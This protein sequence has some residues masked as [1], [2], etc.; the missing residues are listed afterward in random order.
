M[1]LGCACAALG[2]VLASCGGGGKGSEPGPLTRLAPTAAMPLSPGNLD[3]QDEDPSILVGR[4]GDSLWAAWYSN[5]AGLH[6]S[7]RERKEIF[8]A[9][10]SDGFAWTDPPVQVTSHLDWSFYPSLAQ[11]ADGVFHLTWMQWT[12]SPEG[13]VDTS[14]CKDYASRTRYNRSTDGVTWDPDDEVTVST[15]SKDEH[16]WI[17]PTS[18]GRL[19]VYFDGPAGS[20]LTREILVAVHDGAGWDPPQLVTDVSS[21]IEHDSFPHVV[22]RAP[23]S[24]LMTWTRHPTSAP[25]FSTEAETMLS[26]SS[27]GITWTTP[28]VASDP[29]ASTIDVFPFLYPDHARQSWSVLWTTQN[30]TVTRPVDAPDPVVLGTLDIPGYTPRLTPTPTPGIY[31]AAWVDG[32][33]GTEKVRHRF[34]AR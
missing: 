29:L 26:T 27:D 12:L 31:C 28:E 8:I 13:C 18:D 11:S 9:R 1:R 2:I 19:L 25:L 22:E 15:G 10:S 5:R 21:D 34:L 16:A 24:F 14:D 32:P 7:G 33:L 17:V 23:G 6:P 20:S 4:G 30:G 3:R